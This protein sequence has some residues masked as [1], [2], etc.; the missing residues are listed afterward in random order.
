[1][2]C[3]IINSS[4]LLFYIG[5]IVDITLDVMLEKEIHLESEGNSHFSLGCTCRKEVVTPNFT[6]P[7]QGRTL[8]I[9]TGNFNFKR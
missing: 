6:T 2:F 7:A 5:L 1:M 9:V 8:L 4:T 3:Y